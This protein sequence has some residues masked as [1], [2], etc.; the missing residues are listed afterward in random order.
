[1]HAPEC[2]ELLQCLTLQDPACRAAMEWLGSLAQVAVDDS[3][4]GLALELAEEL[5]GAV[6]VE[7]RQ[8]AA[9]RPDLI[10]V[11]LREPQEELQSLM[12][13]LEPVASSTAG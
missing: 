12:D 1:M 4:A 2:R 7:L 11:L 13:L 5:H 3:I 9:L 8:A 10:V 6:G